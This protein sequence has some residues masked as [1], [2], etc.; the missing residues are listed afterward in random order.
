MAP[1]WLVTSTIE[2]ELTKSWANAFTLVREWDIPRDVNNIGSHIVFKIKVIESSKQLKDRPCPHGN[3]DKEEKKSV[4][5]TQQT[6]D[7][8]L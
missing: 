6:Q 1:S 2:D 5:K 4:G 3:K 7:L 8:W